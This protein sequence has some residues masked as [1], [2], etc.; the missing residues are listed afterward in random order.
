[1]DIWKE[2][3]DILKGVM[4]KE[5]PELQNHKYAEYYHYTSLPVLF[6]ILE[7]NEF[8][9]SNVRFSNDEQEERMLNLDDLESRDDY[10]IC[11][12]AENDKLSQWR[13]YCHDGGASIQLYLDA[14][15]N[16][17]I[18]HNDYE[19]TGNYTI[20][21][22]T[23]LPVVYMS[24][25]SKINNN[26]KIIKNVIETGNYSEDIKLID[27]LPY[28]KNGFFYEEKELRLVFSN[29][30]GNLSKCIRFRT[31][32]DGVKVPYM[33]IRCGN[34]GKMNGNCLTEATDY[35]DEVIEKKGENE[36]PIW[37]EE[38]F[39][40]EAKFYEVMRRVD[41]FKKRKSRFIL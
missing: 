5:A 8:W 34:V 27:I 19:Q 17:S 35:S 25:A 28:M 15:Q 29:I 40:Q 10:I 24:P 16:Y 33:V 13:G 2:K 18:L 26:R 31:L 39:N 23:P 30:D 9:V 32:P 20:Y 14:P 38:G 4:K 6:N 36:E 12:C 22:N 7:G 3:W 21:E 41:E 37:I 1:M 11:F